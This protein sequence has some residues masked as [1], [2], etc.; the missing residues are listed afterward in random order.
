M[1]AEQGAKAAKEGV[2][3][4]RKAG[5]SIRTL[6]ETISEAVQSSVQIAVSSEQQLVGMG[7]VSSAM[8]NIRQGSALNAAS[9]KQV[10][11]SAVE[12]GKLRQ[13][14]KQFVEENRI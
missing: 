7:Q 2:E 9:T 3:Q 1:V 12:L 8:E 10:E 11:S 6:A 4:S 5:D 13:K 14:L